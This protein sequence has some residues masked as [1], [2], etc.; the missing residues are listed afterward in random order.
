[1][2]IIILL[3]G[4]RRGGGRGMGRRSEGG[5]GEEGG[6]GRG[7]RGEKGGERR[8]WKPCFVFPFGQVPPSN[9]SGSSKLAYIHQ[10]PLLRPT[11]FAG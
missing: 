5:G 8:G 11:F 3:G 10:P 4:V 6:V 7:E 2:G 1:M 9:E